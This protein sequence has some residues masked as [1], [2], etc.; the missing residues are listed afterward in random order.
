MF[1]F[2]RAADFI[3]GK[4]SCAKS[5]SHMITPMMKRNPHFIT[6]VQRQISIRVFFLVCKDAGLLMPELFL[7]PF[8]KLPTRTGYWLYQKSMDLGRSTNKRTYLKFALITGSF[9]NWLLQNSIS[10][11]EYSL[12]IS[13]QRILLQKRRIRL[14]KLGTSIRGFQKQSFQIADFLDLGRGG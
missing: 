4:P 2:R 1:L 6:R 9:A 8:S 12:L 13:E 14:L 10:L 5:Y 7:I 3:Q 11:V